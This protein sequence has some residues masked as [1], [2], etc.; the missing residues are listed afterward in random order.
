MIFHHIAWLHVDSH[1]FSVFIRSFAG[2]LAISR[3]ERQW[4]QAVCGVTTRGSDARNDAILVDL[5]GFSGEMTGDSMIRLDGQPFQ[6]EYR[7]KREPRGGR[8]NDGT[9]Q[10]LQWIVTALISAYVMMDIEL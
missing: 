2:D 10:F 8:R 7:V 4:P 1:D 6:C 9:P 3:V 5:E